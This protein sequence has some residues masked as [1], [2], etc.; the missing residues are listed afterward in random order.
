MKFLQI[1]DENAELR[2]L[3]RR[4]T[5]RHA[6]SCRAGSSTGSSENLGAELHVSPQL[7]TYYYGFNLD[8]A[9]VPGHRALRRALSMVIDRE[10][11]A[12][13]RA[14]RR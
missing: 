14:A 7:T 11:L 4:R 5:A 2:A 3:P 1:A 13:F 6:R 8:R 12:K 9:P 10:R